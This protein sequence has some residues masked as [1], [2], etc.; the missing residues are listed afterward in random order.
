M[1]ELWEDDEFY[2]RVIEAR[3]NTLS[4]DQVLQIRSLANLGRSIPEITK[5]VE[6]L[7]E[8]QVRN[9]VS[10]RTYKRIH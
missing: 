10:G 4:P 8:A 3:D 6:A 2:L 7:N 5:E 9:V 1:S